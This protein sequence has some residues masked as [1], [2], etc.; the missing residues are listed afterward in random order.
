MQIKL[1]IILA[2]I[3]VLALTL[4][5]VTYYDLAEATVYRGHLKVRIG[6]TWH[7]P[8]TTEYV[9][10]QVKCELGYHDEE[11]IRNGYHFPTN[12]RFKYDKTCMALVDD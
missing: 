5:V 1:L 12:T 2:L 4:G 8:V 10:D 9:I 3:N 7:W 6:N 11:N